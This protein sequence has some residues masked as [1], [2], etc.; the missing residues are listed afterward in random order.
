M[1]LHELF[2]DDID[3][4]LD[5]GATMVWARQGD[6]IVRKYRCTSGR[7]KGKIVS[8]PSACNA[9]TNIKKRQTMKKTRAAKG[10]R[11]DRKARKT[12]RFNPASQRL[13][14][15]NQREE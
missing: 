7:R 2:D 5:E 8:S 1:K 13:A 12:K 10:A 14:R 15:L 4:Q 6:E 11:M 3:N 9:P